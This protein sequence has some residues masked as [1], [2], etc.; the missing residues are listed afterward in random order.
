MMRRYFLLLLFFITNCIDCFADI[1]QRINEAEKEYISNRF[2]NAVF[3]FADDY[4]PL[5]TGAKGIFALN[6][7]QL[8]A[9]E[10]MPIASATKPFTAAGILKLQEQALLNINDK[11]YKYL[12]PEMWGGKVPDWAYKISIHNLLTHS[13]GIAEYFSFVKLDLNM[14]K[15]E[16]HKKILQFVSSKPLEISIGKNFKYSNTNFVILGMIIE[17]VAKKDLANFFYDEFFKPL[18]MKSTSFAS[19]S[20]AARIQKNVISS[21]YPVRYFLT[22]NNSNK[23]IFT[24]VTADFLA[25]PCADGGIIS[26]PVDLIRWYRALNEEKILSK[27]SYKLMT[28]KYF[29]AQDIEGRKSYMGYGIFLTDLDSKRLMI[30]YTGKALGI[31]SEAG[32]VLPDNLY[33]AILSNTMIKI[34]EEEKDKIDMTNPLNQLGIIY[35]RDAIIGAA[36]K[37]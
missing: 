31:Q 2:L 11:I 10:M 29:L 23:P 15:K 3:M 6:G 14:S 18:N 17:K 24:P 19:Y 1:Q 34:P 25:V 8:K 21:N 5:L 7:E 28:T 20:E 37:N 26:T 22:P 13:S 27:K 9:N 16:I 4:K 30:H 12:D 36:I 33:F 32:Y 35:F